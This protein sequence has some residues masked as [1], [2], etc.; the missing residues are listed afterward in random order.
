MGFGVWIGL[1]LDWDPMLA[2]AEELTHFWWLVPILVTA[3]ASAFAL[4]LPGSIMFVIIGLL[5]DPL[6]ATA[7]ISAGGVIGSMLGYLFSQRLGHSWINRLQEHR[8]YHLL[9][10]NTS[11]LMLCAIRTLPGFPH[12]I[13]NYGSGLLHIPLTRFTASALVGYLVKGMLYATAL[14]NMADA[15]DGQ[16][17]LTVDV[18]W[19]LI[20]LSILFILGLAFQ[21]VWIA[22]NGHGRD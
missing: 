7:M 20:V 11:F 1:T 4:A 22:R 2:M 10:S 13:I 5:Y 19:P 18:L 14:H 16:D 15:E 17:L 3:Q 12:S 9:Q 8:L 21:K 6:P